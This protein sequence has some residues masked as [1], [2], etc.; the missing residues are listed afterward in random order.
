MRLLETPYCTLDLD[1]TTSVVTFRRQD[2]PYPSAGVIEDEAKK[3]ERA[4]AS[5]SEGYHLLVD[6]RVI[7]PRNDPEF[8]RAIVQFRR[9]LFRHAQRVAILV[10]TAV[11]ALQV[12]RHS[13]TDGVDARSFQDE[14]QAL[15][16]LLNPDADALVSGRLTP[17]SAIISAPAP[18][19]SSVPISGSV[20]GKPASS[21]GR[22]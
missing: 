9:T 4:L 3:A 19:S 14:H 8:E 17:D 22:G 13:R 12:Q 10:R 11:G 20:P 21:Q 1:G 16:Y 15:A 2:V 6:L 7:L 5:L 18:A